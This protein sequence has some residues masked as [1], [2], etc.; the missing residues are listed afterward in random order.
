MS[1]ETCRCLVAL[2]WVQE[3][4]IIS[5]PAYST[6]RVQ[7]SNATGDQVEVGTKGSFLNEHATATLA[8]YRVVKKHLLAQQAL[9]CPIEQVGQRSSEGIEA[10]LSLNVTP[11]FGIEANGRVL[12]ARF[13]SFISGSRDYAGKVRCPGNRPIRGCAGPRCAS[14]RC[15]R[16]CAMWARPTL[17]MPIS[18][19]SRPMPRWMA[20]CP[21]PSPRV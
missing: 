21:G 12:R 6:G 11:A 16:G 17:T 14:F 20:H 10:A 3:I 1:Q 4:R 9:T 19:A 2:A 8:A 13:D 5:T 18:S 15:A 7:F